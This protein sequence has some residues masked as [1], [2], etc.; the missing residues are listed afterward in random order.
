MSFALEI[1][2]ESTPRVLGN[3]NSTADAHHYLQ[4]YL[5]RK[6]HKVITVNPSVR[7]IPGKL[8]Y[9]ACSNGKWVADFVIRRA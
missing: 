4:R 3:F 2:S 6:G 5:E 8:E 1:V 7:Y 9:S